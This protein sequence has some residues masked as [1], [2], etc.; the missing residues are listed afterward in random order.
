MRGEQTG[1]PRIQLTNSQGEGGKRTSSIH[2]HLD[3]ATRKKGEG[4]GNIGSGGNCVKRG[5][6]CSLQKCTS[7]NMIQWGK[8]R[9]TKRLGR[10]SDYDRDIGEK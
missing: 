7:G 6:G 1:K 8:G 9:D 10:E 5:Y 4:R 3:F 2:M